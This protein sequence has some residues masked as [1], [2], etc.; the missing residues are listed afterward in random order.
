LPENFKAAA[1]FTTVGISPFIEDFLRFFISDIVNKSRLTV[2]VGIAIYKAAWLPLDNSQTRVHLT[3][4]LL[5]AWHTTCSSTLECLHKLAPEVGHWFIT[6]QDLLK[7]YYTHKCSQES[8]YASLSILDIWSFG[9]ALGALN[10]TL[11]TSFVLAGLDPSDLMQGV[12]Q[13]LFRCHSL[14]SLPGCVVEILEYFNF[15]K[16]L[17]DRTWQLCSRQFIM[18]RV[19]QRLN[20]PSFNLMSCLFQHEFRLLRNIQGYLFGSESPNMNKTVQCVYEELSKQLDRAY[21]G[22]K[23]EWAAISAMNTHYDSSTIKDKGH[24]LNEFQSRMLNDEILTRPMLP[25][26][27]STSHCMTCCKTWLT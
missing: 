20:S 12:R 18:K 13:F 26:S 8:K 22:F 10:N 2:L 14:P 9:H 15:E 23:I 27:V 3:S 5:G 24:L 16:V 11:L 25:Q 6:Q 19:Q 21:N 7:L 4:A 17:E 1:A